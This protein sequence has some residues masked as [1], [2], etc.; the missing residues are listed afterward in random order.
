MIDR[1]ANFAALSERELEGRDYRIHLR[2]GWSTIAIVAP[3][4]GGIER[5][6]MEIADAIAGREHMFYCFEGTKTKRN[7]ELHITSDNF[8]EPR[9]LAAISQAE[10][11][12]AIHG[13]KGNDLTVYA[14]GLD[15]ELKKEI[16]E[17]LTREGFAA[18]ND[19]SPRRQGRGLSNICNRGGS[20]MGVQ[21]ELTKG[22]RR[23][24]FADPNP[25]GCT[26]PTAVFDSFVSAVRMV[27]LNEKVAKPY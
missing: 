14:G 1:Y 3:H 4:G 18:A 19:P 5:G 8:D 27:L 10:E 24:M 12:I 16:L 25:G 17:A 26:S 22:L 7:H 20:G 13:A 23:T 15:I 6:T 2:L 11:V 21:L 9:C